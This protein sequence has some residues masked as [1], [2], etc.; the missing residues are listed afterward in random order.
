MEPAPSMQA[1]YSFVHSG[2]YGH[3]F[4]FSIISFI[5]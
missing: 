5:L 2:L 3:V 4:I 1:L